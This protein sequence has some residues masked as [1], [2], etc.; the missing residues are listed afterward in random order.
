MSR[1]CLLVRHLGVGQKHRSPMMIFQTVDI[2]MESNLLV[3]HTT[4]KAAR[5]QDWLEIIDIKTQKT[6]HEFDFKHAVF[7]VIVDWDLKGCAWKQGD[8]RFDTWTVGNLRTGAIAELD[9]YCSPVRVN[10]N[11]ELNL[12]STNMG[13]IR[14]DESSIKSRD[15]CDRVGLGLSDDGA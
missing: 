8:E 15:Q 7:E 12:V 9:L 1:I 2:C 13:Y 11:T 4:D 6:M 14:V 3:V 10:F 5:C